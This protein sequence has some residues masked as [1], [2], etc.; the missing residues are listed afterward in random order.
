MQIIT[1]IKDMQHLAD[2]LRLA[3]KRI[4]FVPTMGALHAGHMSLIDRIRACCDSIVLSIFVNPTQFG[5]TE[6]F[7]S[8]PRDTEKDIEMASRHGCDAVF[9]PDEKELYPEGFQTTVDVGKLTQGLEGEF[10][11]THFRGV[12]TVVTKLFN[13]VKPHVAAFGQKDAQQAMIVRRMTIDLN[14][15]IQ[16]VVSPTVRDLDGL[17]L[18]SR[19]ARLSPEDRTEALAIS[20]ALVHAQMR[21]GEGVRDAELLQREVEQLITHTGRIQV[22]YVRLLRTDDFAPVSALDDNSPVLIAVAARVGNI[23]LID[24]MIL[25]RMDMI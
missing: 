21:Y 23:R 6:D 10:R 8:Y 3:G 11:P 1:S 15:D 2:S 9:L 16:I 4:G 19:N 24:N 22:D 13:I 14:L 20:R 18:S 25:N 12:T 17:A 5:P 7:A